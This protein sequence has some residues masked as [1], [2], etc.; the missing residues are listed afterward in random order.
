VTEENT[1]I[2]NDRINIPVSELSFRF[3]TSSGPGGQHANRAATRAT[4]LFDVA[5]SPS[6]DDDTRTRLLEKLAHRLDKKGVLRIQVQDTRSQ[7]KNREIAASR[8]LALI[9]EA[10]VEEKERAKTKPSASASKKRRD[11]K[12]KQSQRKQGRRT[13]WSKNDF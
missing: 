1:I 6:L 11:E 5:N 12:K 10:L 9:A 7:K 13:D 8:F 2:I 4:L 3:S